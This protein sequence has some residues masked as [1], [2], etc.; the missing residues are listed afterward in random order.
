MFFFEISGPEFLVW[1][2]ALFA[3]SCL[4]AHVVRH[5]LLHVSKETV[6]DGEIDQ[7]DIA[8][9]NGGAKQV[10]FSAIG[11]LAQFGVIEVNSKDRLLVLKE[12]ASVKDFHFVE[13]NLCNTIKWGTNATID[14]LYERF[15]PAVSRIRTRLVK[16]DLLPS[17]ECAIAARTI[18]AFILLI[19][20]AALGLP[21][22]LLGMSHHKPVLFLV[23]FLLGTICAAIYALAKGPVR[24]SLGGEA[25][26]MLQESNASL[27]LNM[28][29]CPTALSGHDVTLAYALFGG[30]LG[31]LAW[32]A[33][34]PFNQAKA[35][36]NPPASS[37]G[38]GSSGG[39]CG[40]GGGCGGC[41][42]CGG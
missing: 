17:E 24:T 2:T 19:I 10:F 29:S 40:C 42:G 27:K 12:N 36:M 41:G 18:P 32:N 4:A 22:L 15:Q 11:T 9:L 38:C 23:M 28:S 3:V 7:Y 14:K 20:P 25:L 39:S 31:G 16:L 34:D 8:Y 5:S 1:Y 35:A 33:Y 21:R 26:T 30:V 37:G 13:E 6:K